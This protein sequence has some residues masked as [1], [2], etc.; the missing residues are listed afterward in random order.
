MKGSHAMRVRS[1]GLGLVLVVF[2]IATG[3]ARPASA[4]DTLVGSM[5]PAGGIG[6]V[7]WSGGT[8]SALATAASA[9]GC[10]AA[11]I[12]LTD[13]GRFIGYTLGA[14]AFVNAAFT[15]LLPSGVL[16]P[17]SPLLLVCG[18]GGAVVPPPATATPVAER[19]GRVDPGLAVSISDPTRISPGTTILPFNLDPE[20]P[21]V[22]EV[23]RFGEIL[24]EYPIPLNLKRYNNP[25]MDAEL[26]PNGNILVE[27]PGN[28]I[29]EV[30]RDGNVV[31]SYLTTKI[32]HD[33]D[34]LPNGNTIFVFGNDDTKNDP[35]VV[36][37]NSTG[38]VVWSWYARTH[39]D[40][41]PYNA[42]SDQGWTHT[43]AVQRLDNGNTLISPRNF[44]FVIEVD[45]SGAVVR[46]IGEGILDDPHDPVLLPSGNLLVATQNSQSANMSI[47]QRGVE[48]DAITGQIV[49]EFP[50]P[51]ESWPVRDVDRMPNGN[52][53][54]TGTS[55]IV[56]VTPDG[57]IVWRLHLTRTFPA[58]PEG[59]EEAVSVGFFK[60]Q[61]VAP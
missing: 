50:R 8:P 46:T 59:R 40:R 52:T 12:G 14:P 10:T 42:I 23:N 20:N 31:W 26:L 21:K 49:W 39:Y 32:S 24:W 22:I 9:R 44:Q 17:Q 55:D 48:L 38:E 35:Q 6:L 43:N 1:L 7:V 16:P 25:G 18:T 34:R 27:L 30:T 29:Y 51:L 61:R 28:G 37:V 19:R 41:A 15:A 36:E 5:P 4:A 2:S 57:T 53:L 13:A 60:S 45:P 56:E 58:G 3:M 47:P 33:A 11:A 54:I